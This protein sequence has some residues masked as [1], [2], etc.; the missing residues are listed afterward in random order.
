MLYLV[1][2]EWIENPAESAEE[3]AAIWTKIADPSVRQLA[4]MVREKTI[5]GGVFAG[6]RAGC[7]I[8]DCKSTEELGQI[9]RDL[10]FWGRLKWTVKALETFESANALERK[11]FECV[12]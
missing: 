4:R 11:I 8:I 5:T 9:I 7:F 10:P 3:A 6:E 12:A 1:T 2:G